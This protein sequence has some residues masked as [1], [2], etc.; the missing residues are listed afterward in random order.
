MVEVKKTSIEFIESLSGGN[1]ELFHTNLLAYIARNHKEYFKSIFGLAKDFD[2][3]YDDVKREYKH[4]D[5]CIVKNGKVA[6]VLENKMKSFPNQKQLE[7][8]Y[9]KIEDENTKEEELK[10]LNKT[11]D[12]YFF[13]LTLLEPTFNPEDIN[14][15]IYYYNDFAKKLRDNMGLIQKDD[16]PYL[17]NFIADYI[18]YLENTVEAIKEA[19]NKF[20]EISVTEWNLESRDSKDYTAI[21]EWKA[22]YCAA[23][24]YLMDKLKKEVSKI[25]SK[26]I[27][28]EIGFSH[29]NPYIGMYIP[30][31]SSFDNPGSSKDKNGKVLEKYFVQIQDGGIKR[32]F[33]FAVNESFNFKNASERYEALAKEWEK[34]GNEGVVKHI[35]EAIHKINTAF[36]MEEYYN[37]K[38]FKNKDG[39]GKSYQKA[40]VYKDNIIPYLKE[41]FKTRKN[42]S[43][44]SLFDCLAEELREVYN[45]I[46]RHR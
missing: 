42:E 23:L 16:R 9:A 27:A 31:T 20:K 14:W 24:R 1:H 19:E 35:G 7:E 13:L 12:C 43:V 33:I 30:F 10:D 8:Y 28:Y 21:F 5:L 22:N 41:D 4:L 45:V 15:N 2:Y 17:V 37:P 44:K 25:D 46:I 36:N 26:D 32:G 3:E 29:G 11:K 34:R 6:F 18:F 40:F 39:R 38:N